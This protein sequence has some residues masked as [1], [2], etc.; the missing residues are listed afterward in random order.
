VAVNADFPAQ[1]GVS[2]MLLVVD[3]C[4]AGDALRIS[5]CLNDL[6]DR[7]PYAQIV[8]LAGEESYPVFERSQ[9]FDRI[10]LSQ[11]YRR[12]GRN[13]G[14]SWRW[15]SWQL[16]RII[17]QL[18]FGYDLIATF[19]WGSN[20]LHL[21]GWIV[22]RRGRRI[23]YARRFPRLL[24]ENLGSY[25]GRDLGAMDLMNDNLS[26][27]RA[28]GLDGRV[29]P[30]RVDGVADREAVAQVLRAN[31]LGASQSLFVLHPGSHWPCQQWLAE[32]WGRL[33]DELFSRYG[34]D[35]VFTGHV[36]DEP[37]VTEIRQQMHAPSV[38]LVGK[39]TL[40]ELAA[41]VRRAR[42]CICVNSSVFEIS[43]SARVPTVVL[44][45]PTEPVWLGRARPAPIVINRT[46]PSERA[47]MN[48]SRRTRTE[49]GS[50]TNYDCPLAY[51][52]DIELTDVLNAVGK[53][54]SGGESSRLPDQRRARLGRQTH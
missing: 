19:N 26:L 20:V 33:A 23:G 38:S 15:K 49:E 47:T 8:L 52:K 10:V 43:Q 9:I 3:N 46:P 22:G 39:T 14:R 24:T 31:N 11:L 37:H 53:Q 28:V 2:R 16:L 30:T 17:W 36:R 44:A 21:I 7:F 51:L 29:T 27:V 54:L 18:G 32:R 40:P 6:R 50:C 42:V 25:H 12:N 35:L 48:A 4:A 1:Q 13:V 34:A 41:L 5:F 45:G